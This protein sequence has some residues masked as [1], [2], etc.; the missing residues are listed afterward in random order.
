MSELPVSAGPRAAM[1]QVF[2]A[3]DG[4]NGAGEL[5]GEIESAGV[6]VGW[7]RVTLSESARVALHAI[8]ERNG[9]VMDRPFQLRHGALTLLRCRMLG[10]GTPSQLTFDGSERNG[11]RS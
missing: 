10:G 11:R 6:S 8:L 2:G 5:L 7:N 4:G 1:T 9:G 3:R